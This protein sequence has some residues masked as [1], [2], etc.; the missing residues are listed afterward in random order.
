MAVLRRRAEAMMG[1]LRRA[2]MQQ[3]RAIERQID[4]LN[5][6]R[7]ALLAEI[8]G[9]AGAGSG[10]RGPGRREDGSRRGRVDWDEVFAKLPKTSFK[11]SDVRV[12][13]PGIAAGTLSQRLTGWVNE[14]K[15]KRTGTRRGT[16]YIRA[17]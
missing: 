14:K 1:R 15:L 17:S 2:G 11:A 10:R 7:Q 9:A 13:A 6:Q 5:Q 3:V 16:R 8:D 12:L 4:R